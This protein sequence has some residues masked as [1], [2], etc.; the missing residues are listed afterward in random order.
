MDSLNNILAIFTILSGGIIFYFIFRNMF[1][2][3][4]KEGIFKNKD[5]IFL[6]V[7]LF[8]VFVVY[9]FLENLHH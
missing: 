8:L 4:I 6:F 2:E 9:Y 5:G 7:T 1:S 3:L